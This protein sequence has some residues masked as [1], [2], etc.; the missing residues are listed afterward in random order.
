MYGTRFFEAAIATCFPV[1]ED[2]V[3]IIKSAGKE[4]NFLAIST[5]PS[6]TL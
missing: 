4:T 1:A 2:P 6:I 3:K 5:F